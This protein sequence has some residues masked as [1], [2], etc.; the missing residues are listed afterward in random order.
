MELEKLKEIIAEVLN[1]D[2][3]E[4]SEETTFMGDLGADSLDIYQIVLK[5]EDAFQIK[6]S[7]E[8]I[9][10]ISNVREAVLLIKKS[11]MQ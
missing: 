6:M 8:E 5:I 2:I 7:A 9:E 1:V 10:K 4:V 3:R 11:E